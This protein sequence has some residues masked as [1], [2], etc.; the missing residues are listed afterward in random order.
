MGTI[1]IILLAS[2]VIVCVSG[3]YVAIKSILGSRDKSIKQFNKNRENRRKEF[4][5]G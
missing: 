1:D 4:E 3:G 5:N 2:T